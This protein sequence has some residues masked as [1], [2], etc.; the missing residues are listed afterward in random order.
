M[1]IA[2]QAPAGNLAPAALTKRGW[3]AGNWGLLLAIAAL[4]TVLLLPTPAELPVAG[5][6]M[7]AVLVLPSSSG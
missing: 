5:H 2:D 4:I 3:I 6:R 1:S 7:L